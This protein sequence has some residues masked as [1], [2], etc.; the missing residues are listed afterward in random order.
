[1]NIEVLVPVTALH[2]DTYLH[3]ATNGASYLCALFMT[4]AKKPLFLLE[5]LPELLSSLMLGVLTLA[6]DRFEVLLSDL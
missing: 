6:S 5:G 3:T 1:M 2:H 4:V